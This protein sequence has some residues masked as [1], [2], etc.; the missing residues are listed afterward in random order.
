MDRLDALL[1]VLAYCSGPTC[2]QPWAAIH[3]DGSVAN[4]AEALNPSYDTLYAAFQKFDYKRCARA[5]E[6]AAGR[7]RAPPLGCWQSGA[8][9]AG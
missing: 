9:A 4:L 1:S 8:G 2:R 6:R 3:P 5:G 7:A